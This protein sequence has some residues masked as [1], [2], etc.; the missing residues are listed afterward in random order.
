MSIEAYLPDAYL[1]QDLHLHQSSD[2]R[3]L[4]VPQPGQLTVAAIMRSCTDSRLT[5]AGS[6]L[7]K[8]VEPK[9]Y[10]LSHMR[11]E[12]RLADT[13]Q[14]CLESFA[15]HALSSRRPRNWDSGRLRSLAADGHDL[16]RLE[17]Y[18]RDHVQNTT[19]LD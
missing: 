7:G 17:H 14:S 9:I 6:W 10:F 11:S 16:R 3:D 12:A 15:H 4:V 1:I 13:V 2:L 19:V 8:Q 18:Q 5:N